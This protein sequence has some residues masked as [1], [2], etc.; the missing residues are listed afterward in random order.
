MR[1]IEEQSYYLDTKTGLKWAKENLGPMSWEDAMSMSDLWRLPAIEE[2]TSLIDYTRSGPATKLP[3]ME[4]VYYWSS[5]PYAYDSYYAWGVYF[6]YGYVY[7]N[8]KP[9][10]Y[11]VRCVRAG[12]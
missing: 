9:N 7:G 1:F 11:Y 2:L 3:R 5:S 12:G 10:H 8:Y 6:C 4:L